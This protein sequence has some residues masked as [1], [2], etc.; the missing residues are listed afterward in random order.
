[1]PIERFNIECY[2][3]Y[4]SD[5]LEYLFPVADKFAPDIVICEN[6]TA[7]KVESQ[8]PYIFMRRY[9][10]GNLNVHFQYEDYIKTSSDNNE[11]IIAIINALGIDAEKFWY[12]LLF[13]SDYVS[14][15]TMKCNATPKEEIEQMIAFIEQNEESISA[16]SGV[17]TKQEMKLSLHIKGKTLNISNPDTLWAISAFCKHGLSLVDENSKL[18]AGSISVADMTD[19]VQ[20]GLFADMFRY[21]FNIYP[22]FKSK[23]KRGNNPT[24]SL[25]RL[26]SKLVYFTKL[27]ANADYDSDDENLKG[28]IK[29]Y[30]N[31]KIETINAIYG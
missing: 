10:S 20:I 13:I 2:S 8:A 25:L 18:N 26:I 6:G 5:L 19:T 21:F 23:R 11:S 29:S 4:E 17:K 31:Q 22:Q 28:I 7:Y 1:M 3:K 15:N 30:S 12:L 24:K 14:G 16:L 9:S 27:T